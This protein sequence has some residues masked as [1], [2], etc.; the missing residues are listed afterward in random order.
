MYLG[1][2]SEAVVKSAGF[3]EEVATIGDGSK[4][5]AEFNGV[6]DNFGDDLVF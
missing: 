1:I 4:I 6:I 5:F 3:D 2:E